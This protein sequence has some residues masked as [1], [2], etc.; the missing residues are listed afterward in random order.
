MNPNNPIADKMRVE[1]PELF[2]KPAFVEDA[3]AL[4]KFG[5]AV[6]GKENFP[7]GYIK[8]FKEDFIV[9][10]IDS[11][12]TLRTIDRENVFGPDS[13]IPG[14][15]DTIYATLVKAG[16]ST[17]EVIRDLSA[18]L[19]LPD[20]SIGYAGIKDKHAITA[21]RISIRNTTDAAFRAIQSPLYFFKDVERGKGAIGMAN[22]TGNRFSLFIRTEQGAELPAIASGDQA[23]YN[24]FYLQRFGS[25]RF[26]NFSWGY[27]ILR[28]DYEK[29]VRS[30]LFEENPRDM[31]Y[32]NQLRAAAKKQTDWKAIKETFSPLLD[33]MLSEAPMLEHL[34]KNPADFKG[35]LNRIP[36]QVQLWLYGLSSL[37]FNE[38][39]SAAVQR[40]T[41]PPDYL[42][43]FLSNERA[44]IETYRQGLT[45]LGIFPPPFQNLR[46]FPFIRLAH[47]TVRT[48]EIAADIEFAP[49]NGG[50]LISFNLPKGSYATTF[51]A[52]HIN[53]VADALPETMSQ[54]R[55][56]SAT[57]NWPATRKETIDTFKEVDAP[58]DGA[59]GA[60]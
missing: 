19:N 40:G 20:K 23:F 15:G 13:P 12:N 16:L 34:I 42:P 45:S 30:V 18:K 56:D 2:V 57:V 51:L 5:I 8:L 25:P 21:Q 47:R 58:T 27:D 24:Y 33:L 10:E 11:T 48:V 35:A 43:F 4:V 37:L 41:M 55:L 59:A 28:G 38:E 49:A 50:F 52:H 36:D 1:H 54:E 29:A 17:L 14:E 53:I 9:E 44:D 39:I 3:E 60:E 32:M 26:I 46:P 6:P 22:L 31:P 7:L